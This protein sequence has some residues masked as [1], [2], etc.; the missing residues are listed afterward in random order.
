MKKKWLKILG[1]IAS[2]CGMAR[3]TPPPVIVPLLGV[4]TT[5]GAYTGSSTFTLVDQYNSSASLVVSNLTVNGV[6]VFNNQQLVNFTANGT[7]LPAGTLLSASGQTLNIL[8]TS[9]TVDNAVYAFCNIFDPN[10]YFTAQAGHVP[11]ILAVVTDLAT[12]HISSIAMEGRGNMYGAEPQS[13]G[14]QGHETHIDTQ[15]VGATTTLIGLD[16]QLENFGTSAQNTYESSG[17]MIG[18]VIRHMNGSGA[19][20]QT[21]A[22]WGMDSDP[23][24]FNGDLAV[25]AYGYIPFGIPVT[26]LLPSINTQ[27]AFRVS[28]TSGAYTNLGLGGAIVDVGAISTVGNLGVSAVIAHGRLDGQSGSL[29]ETTI[30]TPNDISTGTYRVTYTF[31]VTSAGSGGT[32]QPI[33]AWTDMAQAD[34]FAGTTFAL[35]SKGSNSQTN[36]F[37]A[38]PNNPIQIGWTVASA[39]GSPVFSVDYIIERLN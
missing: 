16:S 31:N 4:N 22:W 23:Y 13:V 26:N 14:V 12:S 5:T 3:A 27:S 18:G 36:S 19:P 15:V 6:N 2:F 29:G 32:V 33:G 25:G 8:V 38:R 39:T 37:I 10:A 35:T 9:N 28:S 30:L 17:T 34:S 7:G 24:I 11:C 20:G 1:V 21:L